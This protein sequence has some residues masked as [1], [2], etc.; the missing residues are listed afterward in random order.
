MR[1]PFEW[2]FAAAVGALR[3]RAREKHARLAAQGVECAC[4]FEIV[5]EPSATAPTLP[6]LPAWRGPIGGRR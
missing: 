1:R 3:R 6:A 5:D 4:R 2:G